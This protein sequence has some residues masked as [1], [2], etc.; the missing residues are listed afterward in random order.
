MPCGTV[1]WYNECQ[2]RGLIIPDLGKGEVMFVCS[3][4][5]GDGFRVLEAGQRVWF[6]V[7]ETSRG[8][9]AIKVSVTE[10]AR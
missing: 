1:K 9:E 3:E 2:G 4:V 8:R 7:G 5:T 6:D 10:E